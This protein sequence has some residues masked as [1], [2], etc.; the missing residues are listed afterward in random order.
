MSAV[1]APGSWVKALAVEQSQLNMWCP[2]GAKLTT[3]ARC[4]HEVFARRGEFARWDGLLY[5]HTLFTV[6]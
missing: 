2:R 4:K 3:Y 1:E 6:R 5:R